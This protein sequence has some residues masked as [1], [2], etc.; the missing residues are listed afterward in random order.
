MSLI[1][2]QLLERLFYL[3]YCGLKFCTISVIKMAESQSE[4]DE[5]DITLLFALP[6]FCPL[7]VV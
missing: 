5:V 6:C 4:V 1:L 3:L 2:L 7:R